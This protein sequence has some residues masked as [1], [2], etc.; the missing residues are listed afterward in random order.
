[1]H[2]ETHMQVAGGVD[3][4]VLGDQIA[5]TYHLDPPTVEPQPAAP[6]TRPPGEGLSHAPLCAHGMSSFADHRYDLALA[7]L[8]Q[9]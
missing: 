9:G 8:R 7:R 1:M 2:T 6:H 3:P 4:E 5:D